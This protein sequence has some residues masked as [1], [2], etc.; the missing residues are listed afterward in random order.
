MRTFNYSKIKEEKWDSEIL[1]LIAAIYSMV[2]MVGSNGEQTR[3]A[4]MFAVATIIFY[5]MSVSRKLD[6]AEGKI[7]T[8][9][10]L[11][12]WVDT[13]TLIM[14]IG[15][16]AAMFWVSI[17]KDHTTPIHPRE[18]IQGISS[19]ASEIVNND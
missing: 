5:E 19:T 6:I 12:N 2:A 13:L 15:A 3:W 18:H 11:P 17:G 10:L 7:E 1:G 8:G 4:L 16:L 14:T 9:G